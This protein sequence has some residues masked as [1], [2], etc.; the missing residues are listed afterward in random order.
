M[1]QREADMK[2]HVGNAS[3]VL[4]M[5]RVSRLAPRGIGHEPEPAFADDS[6]I[7]DLSRA[8]AKCCGR[9]T[10]VIDG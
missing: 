3:R 2:E 4:A 6:F 9:R 8:H 10:P 7:V 1:M 5:L